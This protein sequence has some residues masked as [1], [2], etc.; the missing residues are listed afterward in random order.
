MPEAFLDPFTHGALG[1]ACAQLFLFK[2]DKK[3]AWIVGGLAAMAPD[4]DVFIRSAQ[5]PM[6]ALL[7][8]RYFTHS[9]IFIPIGALIVSLV[10]MVFK[11]F[12]NQW[13]LTYLA[14]FIGYATHGVLDACTNYGTV[15]LWP[16]SLQRISW[17]TISIVD[18]FFTFPLILGL[19][20]SRQFNQRKAIAVG[21]GV[22]ILFMGFNMVQQQR[23][24]ETMKRY[25]A[26][27]GWV[28]NHW[29]VFPKLASSLFWRGL[30]QS[31]NTLR[32]MDITTPPFRHSELKLVQ[33]YPLFTAAQLPSYVNHSPTLLRD[34]RL[35]DWFTNG[36]MIGMNPDKLILADG[37]FLMDENSRLSL[38]GVAFIPDKPH[39]KRLNFI[40]LP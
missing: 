18:P 15:L 14:A 7:Y 33:E 1:A 21:L 25:A 36:Y 30:I 24:I 22:S 11:R 40:Y 16:F 38:W 19:V 32:V 23:A 20:W 29:R 34:Y 9:L 35:F 39:I 26:Q 4:L 13:H 6:L 10:L 31:Q 12:R 3:N 17:D 37:R 2:K 27:Q 8:H 5:D 28:I